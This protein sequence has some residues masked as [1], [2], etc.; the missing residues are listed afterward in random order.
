LVASRFFAGELESGNLSFDFKDD[1]I[2]LGTFSPLVSKEYQEKINQQ[3]ED[4]KSTGLLPN[5]K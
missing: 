2:S 5:E 3:I 1:V 4:Y